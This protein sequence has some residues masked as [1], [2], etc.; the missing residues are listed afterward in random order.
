MNSRKEMFGIT[1]R[2]AREDLS[3]MALLRLLV[4]EGRARLTKYR[5]YP[6]VSKNSSMKGKKS[7]RVSERR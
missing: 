5:L 1:G 3:G 7:N 6:E 4:K 2:Q